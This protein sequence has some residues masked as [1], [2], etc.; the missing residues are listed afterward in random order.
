MGADRYLMKLAY[1][2]TF[3]PDYLKAFY[4]VRRE[5]SGRSFIEQYK[6]IIEDSFHLAGAWPQ[7]LSPLGYD[8]LEVFADVKPLQQ[9]WAK[10]NG[11]AWPGVGWPTAVAL[12]QLRQFQP[13][14]LL[15]DN[16]ILFD[17]SWLAQLRAE[18]PS[19]RLVIGFSSSPSRDLGTLQRCDAVISS[20]RP[21]V[22]SF[23]RAGCRAHYLRHGFNQSILS[24]LP[25]RAPV[26]E[27]M[28]F[29]GSI[30]R[31]SGYHFERE[32]LLETLVEKVPLA[33]YCPQRDIPR[34]RD[35]LETALRRGL[36]VLLASL[37]ALGLS[38]ETLSR[39]PK[40]G[41]AAGWTSLPENRTSPKLK[42]YMR[43]AIF[44]MEM[45]TAFRH[46]ALALNHHGE[47]AGG[48]TNNIRVFEA[49]GAG[50]CLLTDWTSDLADFFE[51]DREVVAYRSAEECGEKARWLLGHPR[52][53]EAIALAGQERT[54][55]DHSYSQR[56][57]EL[58]RIIR[59][60]L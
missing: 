21:L 37:R 51:P 35:F 43:P 39:L 34:M 45:M 59:Q 33:W 57:I 60:S 41:R 17:G 46:S 11:V 36:Y 26:V 12:A 6:A 20:I 44:G 28:F 27:E 58:D 1:L 4:S 8:V 25:P 42:P 3:Y 38:Q 13:D 49:T 54:L 15:L 10:E 47:V 32:R 5:L 18:C 56:G 50:S 7:G 22:E 30:V 24:R 52:E 40:I 53:R 16:T 31:A 19:L 9:A 23:R 48:M 29:A 14:I 2:T 55:R